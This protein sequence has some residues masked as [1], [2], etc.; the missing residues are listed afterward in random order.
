MT[1]QQQL[2]IDL[3]AQSTTGYAARD[4]MVSTSGYMVVVHDNGATSVYGVDGIN[5]YTN[6]GVAA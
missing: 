5:D 4:I 1:D 2:T 6:D 3:L